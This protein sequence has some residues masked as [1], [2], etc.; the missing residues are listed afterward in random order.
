M[1]RKTQR[2]IEKGFSL[3]EMVMTLAIGLVLASVALPFI[4][5]AVQ[6]YRLNGI[7]QQVAS[8]IDLTRYTAIRRNMIVSLQTTTDAARN[9]ILYVDMHH[10]TNLH[11]DDPM[12][13]IPNDMQIGNGD[14]NSATHVVTGPMVAF[15]SSINFDYRGV[16]NYSQPGVTPGTYFI[17]I[18]YVSHP[19][20]GVRAVTL[21]PMG[22]TKMW[23]SP[24]GSSA[25]IAM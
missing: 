5:N 12:V 9:T 20:Y 2:A 7:T 10:D 11:A 22:Q 16:V 21:T 19:Q 18:G 17:T 24:E 4:V 13:L 15:V 25:W 8:L 23:T 14:P 1:S 3:V 6:T